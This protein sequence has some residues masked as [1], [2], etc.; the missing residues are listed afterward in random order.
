MAKRILTVDDSSSIR[1]FV[2]L[3]LEGAGYGVGE[4]ADAEAGMAMAS[5]GTFDLIITDLNMPGK[6][7]LEFLKE[8]RALPATRKT[9]VVLLTTATGE[10]LKQA[11][12]AAG[13]S[14]W[15]GKPFEPERLLQVVGKLVD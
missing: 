9:P 2:R 5:L 14:G 12:K 13:A 6:S 8:L 3:T 1:S 11:A 7:G 4:A 15:M 10:E